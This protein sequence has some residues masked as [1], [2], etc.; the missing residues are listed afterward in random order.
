MV[1]SNVSDQNGVL[2]VSVPIWSEKNGQDDIIWYNAT[3]LSN[4]N[5]KV[6]VSLSDHKNERGLYNVHLYYV[7][8][9]GKLVGVGGTT[10]T[11][12][13]KVEET[14]TTTSHSLPDSGTYAFKERSSIKAEPRVASPE[15][16]YYDAGM[17]VNYDKIVSGDG[18][19]W[20]SYL[21]YQ[22]VLSLLKISLILVSTFILLMFLVGTKLFKV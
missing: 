4:G 14:H 21:S 8:T 7:E 5:Y 3:R 2:G 18:Y 11:V 22:A 17:S 16:A 6:N 13:A 15:L 19:Q 10:Y 1:I 20:L 9:N 12:P